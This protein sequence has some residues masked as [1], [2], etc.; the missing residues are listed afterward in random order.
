MRGKL[1]IDPYRVLDPARTAEA[2]LC[3]VRL[4]ASTC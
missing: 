1:V 4:G 2:G 3:V